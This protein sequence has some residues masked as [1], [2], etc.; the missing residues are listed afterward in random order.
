M[1]GLCS[2]SF[3]V[4]K[5]FSIPLISHFQKKKRLWIQSR[6]SEFV[7]KTSLT[8]QVKCMA[9]ITV[10]Y[11]ETAPALSSLNKQQSS[12]STS[13]IWRSSLTYGLPRSFP[14]APNPQELLQERPSISTNLTQLVCTPQGTPYYWSQVGQLNYLDLRYETELYYLFCPGQDC[15]LSA[16]LHIFSI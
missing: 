15:V 1:S 10:G 7:T 16:L 14:I 3:F 2:H 12:A 9:E 11:L 8:S 6:S 13:H 4:L 5:L